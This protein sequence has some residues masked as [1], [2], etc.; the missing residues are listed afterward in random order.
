M[1]WDSLIII[2]QVKMIINIEVKSG[3]SLNALKKAASQTNIHQKIFKKIFGAHLSEEWKFVK[4]AFTPNL[5]I[6]IGNSQPCEYCKQF[7]ITD[8]QKI[9]D[10]IENLQNMLSHVSSSSGIRSWFRR[11]YNKF[12][13]KSYKAEYDNLLVGIIGYSSLRHTETLNKKIRDPQESIQATKEKV[14]ASDTFNDSA[15]KENI[16]ENENLNKTAYKCYMLT[17]D[18]LMAVKDPSSHIIIEGDYGCGKTYVL[19][20]RTKQ[21]AEKYPE[22]NIAY[23]N[24][25]NDKYYPK[26]KGP[27]S[28]NMMDMITKNNFKDYNNVDVVTSKDLY[29]HWDKQKGELTDV[30]ALFLGHGE[31]S[32]LVIEHF[33]KHSKY[34]HIFIDE[35]PSFRIPY[36]KSDLFSADKTFC[37]TMK[38]EI[39]GDKNEEWINQMEER[40]NAK[41]FL[42]KHNMRNSQ[43]IVH[44]SDS[45]SE[46]FLKNNNKNKASL[47][48]NKNIE[49]PLC[50]HYHNIH[51]LD[52]D[53][54]ARAAIMKY[55]PR[56]NES[57]VILTNY[58][59]D[60]FMTKKLHR[61]L[62]SYFYKDRNIVFLPHYEN[63]Y[64]KHTTNVK[65]YLENPEGILV[66]DIYSF[67]GAQA[68]NIIMIVDFE[69]YKR[70][71][72][73]MI[74]R[75]MSIAI[76][77]HD[78]DIKHSVPGLVRDDNLHE[79]INP[80]NTE[81]LFC[82]NKDDDHRRNCNWPIKDESSSRNRRLRNLHTLHTLHAE[83]NSII[84]R[85]EPVADDQVV[86][87]GLD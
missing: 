26:N 47:T 1:E 46:N 60:D 33:L 51:E 28:I 48:L 32:S 14:T 50:Y 17:P 35:I 79:Y 61:E 57:V 82:N 34:H 11:Y 56:Q 6:K 40:Y 76:I 23:I 44:L 71:I 59:V 69:E 68:R 9:D 18:Q 49:G 21:C 72:R 53:V 63:N 58:F 73:N 7:V 8:I 36:S 24:L 74:M 75:T 45:L 66:T 54:L 64:E 38:Y 31:K 30:N 83:M 87:F 25:T 85:Q 20:E 62:F 42:L 22:E 37:I 16:E 4:V 70:N 3:P 29:D 52:N 27:G 77:I 65:D 67:N 15:I 86:V 55:F 43:T 10:W 39:F 13:D 5:S 81:Q 41:R 2:P 80:G 84:I 78:K 12:I 19:K